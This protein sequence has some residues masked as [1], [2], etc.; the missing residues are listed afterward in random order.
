MG[1]TRTKPDACEL[2]SAPM[3]ASS[4]DSSGAS[5]WVPASHDAL[6][7]AD[8]AVCAP[9][10]TFRIE[11]LL[12]IVVGAH[13][14]AEIADRPLANRLVRLIRDWQA[15]TLDDVD[16]ALMPVVCSD[17]WFLNDRELMQQPCIAIGEPGHNAATAYYA[18]RLPKT[19]V[20]EDVCAIQF[21]PQF[22]DGSVCLWGADVR[23]TETAFK[24]F[25]ERH[26]DSYLRAI[27]FV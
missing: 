1:G 7:L 19:Y 15:S 20:I 17:V 24:A 22:L 2:S 25:V 13:M 4:S 18:S 5:P 14:R 8:R 12:V 26:L 10:I 23:A 9:D 3:N 27:H 11:D 21:D 16:T 6:L